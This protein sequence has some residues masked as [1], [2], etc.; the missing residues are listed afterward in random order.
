MSGS[1]EGAVV[2]GA[3]RGLGRLIAAL[4]AERG[5]RVL[6]TDIDAAAARATA[7]ELG[8]DVLWAAL[9]VRDE[10]AV[11]AVRDRAVAETGGLG[12]WVNNAGVLLTGPAW[13]QSPAARRLM[14]EVNT[15]GTINGTVAAIEAMRGTGGHIVNIV[16]LAGLTAVPGEAVYAASKH[17][18]IGFSVSTLADLRLAG[19]KDIDIS[20]VCP[21][22]IWTPMLHDKLD[23]PASALSF[24]GRLLRPADVV[25]AVRKVLDRPRPVTAVPGRRGLQARLAGA[26]PALGLRALPLMVAK[27]RR[28]QR[29]MLAEARRDG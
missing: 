12:V 24:S 23:D 17:A 3:G 22:G 9:D 15:L 20:C 7:E 1:L 28:V 16:S 5:H 27:G 13:D 29:R 19:T 11:A 6:V 26:L 4:L 10:E 18:A 2:T 14:L 21:D 25:A 8:P